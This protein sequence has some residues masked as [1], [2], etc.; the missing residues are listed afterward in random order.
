MQHIDHFI[1]IYFV[2]DSVR[3]SLTVIFYTPNR[4]KI[5][6]LMRNILAFCFL[7]FSSLAYSQSC[8]ISGPIPINPV[9]TTDFT[10]Q[11]DGLVNDDLSTAGQC[12]SL[13][14]LGFEHDNV[15]TLEVELISP[16]GQSVKLIGAGNVTSLGTTEFIDWN[17]V[18][19]ND[20][21]AAAPDAGFG[22]VWD[23]NNAWTSFSNYTG[24]YYPFQGEFSD[25]NTGSAN[26]LWTVRFEDFSQFSNGKVQFIEIDFCDPTGLTCDACYADSGIFEAIPQNVFCEGDA[27]LND[28]SFFKVIQNNTSYN[29]PSYNY[30]VV[31]GDNILSFN[32][33]LNLSGLTPGNYTVCGV[34]NNSDDQVIL[35]TETSYAAILGAFANGTFCGDAMEINEC[36]DIVIESVPNTSSVTETICPGEV[37]VV[38]GFNFYETVDTTIFSYTPGG[39]DEA[40]R[41]QITV[42][43]AVA[44]IV[45]TETTIACNGTLLLNGTTSEGDNLQFN[46]FTESGSFDSNQGPIATISAPGLY[47]LE[48]SNGTCLDTS[49]IEILPDPSFDNTVTIQA[50]SLGCANSVVTLFPTITGT[51]DDVTWSGPGITDPSELEPTVSEPG[52]Y[53][54][55]INNGSSACDP[56]SN[57]I[58]IAQS[59]SATEPFFNNFGEL[60]CNE[61]LIIEVINEINAA[62]T[63][64]VN[65][66]GDTIS[67]QIFVNI[68]EIG[69]YTFQ[70]IDA[71]GCYGEKTI[72]VEGDIGGLE[73][74]FVVDSLGCSDFEGQIFTSV[75]GQLEN[76]FWQGQGT[77]NQSGGG[78]FSADLNPKVYNPGLYIISAEDGEGCVTTD[79]VKIEYPESAFNMSTSVPKINCSNREATIKVLPGG[80]AFDYAWSKPL[81][82]LI[83]STEDKLT[84]DAGGYYFVSITRPSDGCEI[85]VPGFIQVD[86]MPANLNFED[87][88]IDCDSPSVIIESDANSVPLVDFMW[89]GPGID[90]SNMNEKFPEVSDLGTYV[91]SGSSSNGCMFQ[92]TFILEIDTT[93]IQLTDLT[94]AFVL[95]CDN[96]TAFTQVEANREGEFVWETPSGEMFGPEAATSIDLDIDETGAYTVTVTA[97]NGCSDETVVDVIY[98]LAPPEVSFD[99]VPEINCVDTQADL[100][101]TLGGGWESFSWSHDSSITDQQTTVDQAGEYIVTA[102]NSAGCEASDTITIDDFTRDVEFS[103]AADTIDCVDMNAD[104]LLETMEMN[105]SFT[106]AGPNGDL[107]SDP[108]IS[109]TDGDIYYVTVTGADGCEGIDSIEV[110]ANVDTLAFELLAVDTIDCMD[111]EVTSLIDPALTQID[112]IDNIQWILNGDVEAEGTSGVLSQ[113][114]LYTVELTGTNGCV[115]SL[116]LEVGENKIFPEVTIESD[117]IDCINVSAD[118]EA[119]LT[120]IDPTLRWD[121]PDGNVVGSI[122][123]SIQVTEPG[124]YI[125]TVTDS[126]NCETIDSIEVI[127][128]LDVPPSFAN[129]I[130]LDCN[131]PKD[132]ITLENYDASNTTIQVLNPE[133]D[134]LADPFDSISVGGVYTLLAIGDNGCPG[135]T[136]FLVDTDL[137]APIADVDTSN[138]NCINTEGQLCVLSFSTIMSYD[139]DQDGTDLGMDQDCITTTEAGNFSVVVTGDNGCKDTITRMIEIDTI[140]PIIE[141]AQNGI[142]ACESTEVTLSAADSEGS[143]LIYNWSTTDGTILTGEEQIDL[144]AGAPGTYTLELTDG[145]NGCMSTS[146]LIVADESA[147][148]SNLDL[149]AMDPPC[150]NQN[151]GEIMVINVEGGYGSY[152]YSFDGGAS[153]EETDFV[154]ELEAGDYTVIIK[155]SLGCEIDTMITILDGRPI[156]L[157]LGQD[158]TINLGETLTILPTSNLDPNDL[159]TI[160]WTATEEGFSCD[161]CWETDLMPFGTTIYTV[162]IIDEFGC[163]AEDRII[164]QVNDQT[165]VYIPNV[166]DAGGV[167]EDNIV[168]FNAGPAVQ[169][170]NK[171][172]IIDRWGSRI[173]LA[174]NFEAN[175]PSIAWDGTAE[176]KPVVPGVYMY[177]AEVILINGDLRTVAGDITVFR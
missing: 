123:E 106:W 146:T 177:I 99:A 11:V 85:R 90:A 13:L 137:E 159:M 169:L 21:F 86:T 66:S 1:G 157:D 69:Q 84:I 30:L 108:T 127:G 17:V 14:K 41:Y 96:L 98:G 10:F 28:E 76:F 133:G 107:G 75:N 78:F 62:E 135:E 37:Y 57:S 142:I 125:I 54:I 166:L 104:I 59:N 176:G 8:A 71:F 100:S 94:D 128:D 130:S 42:A 164:V 92:D 112:D 55:T 63:A 5:L 12:V 120:G 79:T 151:L 23:N 56:V 118:L 2:I 95:D 162:E 91:I 89:E 154:D 50:D 111:T 9:G 172:M 29:N 144:S 43:D 173:F 132:V 149:V 45:S 38:D 40:V 48:V 167:D 155:D 32:Q 6:P 160:D 119:T 93:V 113:G 24:R 161:G 170:V 33:N 68:R 124:T 3:I 115:S 83:L 64:W 16:Q 110:I 52:I 67:N 141:L 101:V 51:Y 168:M 73:L 34:I 60:S 19:I 80:S 152:S 53:T 150:E 61:N 26:G 88:K 77:A 44:N 27:R 36:I 109:V 103:L 114:G 39:C 58:L 70:F 87:N 31:E 126:N 175:D 136:V 140:S 122:D 18:F 131:D 20:A 46:W 174:E 49:M 163:R 156:E 116:M 35:E 47:F 4:K 147:I 117:T 22:D 72:N 65:S 165:P 97:S 158:T 145:V 7:L 143:A 129:D 105:P 74:S 148:L 102:F 139:W 138:I 15:S 25:I 153:F 81:S 82:S 134:L 121:G 171:W